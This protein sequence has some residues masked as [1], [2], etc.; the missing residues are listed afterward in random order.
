MFVI[1]KKIAK[2]F[3]LPF[4]FTWI[5]I[6]Q[7]RDCVSKTSTFFSRRGIEPN[8]TLRQNGNYSKM[9][10]FGQLLTA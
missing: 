1:L 7:R 4:N 3:K 6:F 5:I 2:I 9:S 10:D 8:L